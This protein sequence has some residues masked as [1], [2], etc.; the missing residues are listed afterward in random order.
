MSDEKNPQDDV[1]ES[2]E[3][4]VE[5]EDATGLRP[6][7]KRRRKGAVAR[8]STEETSSEKVDNKGGFF[9]R[10]GAG[11]AN[12]FKA[13]GGYFKSIW[14]QLRKVIWPTKK[15]MVISVIAVFVFLIITV[16]LIFGVDSGAG[17]L[18]RVIFQDPNG[19]AGDV[20]G[21]LSGLL[22]GM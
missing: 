2:A 14:D 7:G 11:I 9:A 6:T 13:L 8:P 3:P 17:E 22:P 4:A 18:V 19:G 10:V 21:D 1:V 15:E 12:F 20:P 5:A 16:L